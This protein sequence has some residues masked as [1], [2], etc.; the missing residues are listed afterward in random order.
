M[1]GAGASPATTVALH[2]SETLAAPYATDIIINMHEN[3]V[4]IKKTIK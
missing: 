4:K 2:N 1:G 3:R